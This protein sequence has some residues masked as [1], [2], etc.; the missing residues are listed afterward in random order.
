MLKLTPGVFAVL[1]LISAANAATHKVPQDEPVA[2]LDVPDKWQTMT[3][4]EFIEADSADG[5]VHF[6]ATSPEGRKVMEGMG[7]T[8]RYIRNKTGLVVD[9]SS[10]KQE[11]GRLNG[12]NVRNVSWR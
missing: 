1:I 2:L 4:D 6:I 11:P 12:M 9:A 3:H 5:T 10:L 8:M 7:E